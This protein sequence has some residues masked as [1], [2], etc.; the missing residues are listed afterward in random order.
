[1]GNTSDNYEVNSKNHLHNF[2]EWNP[3]PIIEINLAGE[4]IY[5]NLAA[6]AQFPNLLTVKSKH[7]VLIGLM[8]QLGNLDKVPGEFVV[9]FREVEFLTYIYEQQIFSFADKSSVFIFMDDITARKYAEKQLHKKNIELTDATIFLNNILESSVE[10][11]IIAT[12]LDG[13]ILT[14]NAGAKHNYGFDKTE[15]TGKNISVL[16]VPED[17]QSGRVKTF[18]ES[19]LDKGKAE[20][21]FEHIRK[22]GERFSA[23]IMMSVRKDEAGHAAGFLFIVKDITKKKQLEEQIRINLVHEEQKIL[24]HEKSHFKNEF[25]TNLSQTLSMALDPIIKFSELINDEQL[26]PLTEGQKDALKNILGNA[27]DL[28]RMVKGLKP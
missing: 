22:S 20:K 21:E 3:K 11:S 25:L 6:R 4:I 26:G 9:F 7:P 16:Y 1:M 28:L 14:W 19:V 23:A 17:N 15:M 8:D 10:Y 2:A 27:K 24:M 5:F 12:D 18:M 13:T